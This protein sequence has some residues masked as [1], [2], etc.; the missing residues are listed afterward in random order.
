MI[1]TVIVPI[2]LLLLVGFLCV[3][4]EVVSAEHL[5]ALSNFVIKVALPSLLFCA[6]ANKTMAEIWHPAYFM[7]YGGGSILLYIVMFLLCRYV[8][9]ESFT[10]SAV[11]AVGGS[12]S[13][14][15]F[16][17][18]AILTLLLGSHATVYISLTLII[19]SLI[20][21]AS[22]FTLAEAG[23]Q[24]SQSFIYLLWQTLKKLLKTPVILAV[25]LG[26][27]C[28]ILDIRLFAP[29]NQAL[30]LIGNTA[31]P[32]A[33]FVIGGSLVGISLKSLGRL[34]WLLVLARTVFMPLVI[35]FLLSRFSAVSKEMLYAGTLL[36]ALPMPA[37]FGIFGQYYGVNEKAM[38]P[39]ILS[40]FL[41]F[42]GVSG[43]IF[44]WW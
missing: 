29:L 30:M 25:I 1:F 19:E 44:L 38:M 28:V 6:L 5:Q 39:L 4:Y 14:T 42:I 31:S 13:N 33:L 43:L 10:H 11:L 36:A 35:Y 20:I 18:T 2:L 8:F 12:M 9:R 41:G 23:L 22:M 34:G 24:Q 3:R 16:I 7:A 27:G 26:M 21:L 17:G 15:G 40:T 32:L 37:A